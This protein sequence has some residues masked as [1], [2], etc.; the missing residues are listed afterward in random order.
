MAEPPGPRIR[1]EETRSSV[2][3]HQRRDGPITPLEKTVG[4]TAGPDFGFAQPGDTGFS[5]L[6]GV[7]HD[8]PRVTGLAPVS[9][10]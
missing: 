9:R 1:E 3:T 6:S 7:D 10:W 4:T 5:P 8:S 2:P